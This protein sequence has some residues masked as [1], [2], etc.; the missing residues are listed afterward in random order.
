MT[1]PLFYK[2][3]TERLAPDLRQMCADMLSHGVSEAAM[4]STA[5]YWVPVWNSLCE[6]MSLKLVN[7]YFIKQLPGRKSDVKDAQWIA[8]CVLKNLI[9][10]SFVLDP[11]VQ[12]MRKYNRRIF[13]LNDDMVYNTNKLDAALQRCGFRL[14]N[15]VAQ[16]KGQSYQKCVKAISKE[17][18]EPAELV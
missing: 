2:K 6:S 5:T 13:D 14:N 15:S 8:E 16:V 17:I 10:G 7:P 1:R 18:T 11:V 4:E 12:N 9:R 3:H